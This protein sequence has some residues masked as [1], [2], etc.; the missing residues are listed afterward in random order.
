[1][2]T[3]V[4]I[5]RSALGLIYLAFGLDFFLNFISHIVSFPPLDDQANS[6]LGALAAAKYFFPFLKVTEIIFGLF[7]LS[8]RN[9][10]LATI[11]LFPITVNIF[12]FHAYMAHPVVLLGTAMLVLNLFLIYAYRRYYAALFMVSPEV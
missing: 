1:M 5:A 2:K 7:L 8:N 10:L 4:L 12:L 6:F 9:A 3:A 11:A